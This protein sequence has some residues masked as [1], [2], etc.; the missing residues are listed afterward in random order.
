[1]N[2]G[3]ARTRVKVP[4]SLGAGEDSVVGD[5]VNEAL[6]DFTRD[7]WP[8]MRPISFDLVKGQ[9][10]YDL[11]RDIGATEVTELR[12]VTQA[13]TMQIVPSAGSV[14]G[15]IAWDADEATWNAFINAAPTSSGG[16]YVTRNDGSGLPDDPIIV[17]I[18]WYRRTNIS[19]TVNTFSFTAGAANGVTVA[20]LIE[21]GEQGILAFIPDRDSVQDSGFNFDVRGNSITLDAEPL[22]SGTEITGWIVPEPALLV[23]TTD[24]AVELPLPREWHRAVVYRAMQLALEWD[25]QDGNQAAAYEAKY[26]TEVRKCRRAR[27]W[28]L[29][30]GVKQGLQPSSIAAPLVW[31][32]Q[33]PWGSM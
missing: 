10:S 12:I 30:N 27:A 32:D 17:R 2:F 28:A 5:L 19:V 24:D 31:G 9:T 1:M 3:A 33:F 13:G 8:V 14:P 26:E 15:F 20:P 16:G 25:M 18:R 4:L 22:A 11:T 7:A 29:G 6:V 23:V 21:G